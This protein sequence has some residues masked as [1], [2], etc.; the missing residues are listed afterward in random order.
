[1]SLDWLLPPLHKT[2]TTSH[3]NKH[4]H[5]NFCNNIR[6]IELILF[7]TF[8]KQGPWNKQQIN[9]YAYSKWRVKNSSASA[10]HPVNQPKQS[11]SISQLITWNRQLKPCTRCIPYKTTLPTVLK[12][13]RSISAWHMW[14][15]CTSIFFFLVWKP[16]L[17]L[18]TFCCISYHPEKTH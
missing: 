14:C 1:M 9:N 15:L 5:F 12:N 6:T 4:Q 11:H 8:Q 17:D 18:F 7:T 3:S 16:P 13:P 2:H 10:T